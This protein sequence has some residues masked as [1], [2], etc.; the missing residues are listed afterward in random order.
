MFFL[1]LR[2]SYSTF[3]RFLHGFVSLYKTN[4]PVR[5]NLR[6]EA[7]CR[8]QPG[9]AVAT[10]AKQYD[11]I[12]TTRPLN[13]PE[14]QQPRLP[15]LSFCQASLSKQQRCWAIDL[16]AALLVQVL[17][18]FNLPTSSLALALSRGTAKG[19][20]QTAHPSPSPGSV[21]EWA[22]GRSGLKT[23]FWFS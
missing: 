11:L 17:A 16:N 23:L 19:N 14:K 4:R 13:I 20:G 12:N 5:Q 10:G 18:R 7:C 22:V 21:T 9:Y 2:L 6:W 1:P 8:L 15:P 3:R